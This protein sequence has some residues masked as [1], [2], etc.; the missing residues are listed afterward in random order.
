[1]VEFNSQNFEELLNSID[2]FES[3]IIKRGTKYFGGENNLKRLQNIGLVTC[4]RPIGTKNLNM[5]IIQHILP[6]FSK[7]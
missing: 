6:N 4:Y 5:F 3:E 7:Q 2:E 1:M